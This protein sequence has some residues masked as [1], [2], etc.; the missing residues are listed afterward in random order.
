M[1]EKK[2]GLCILPSSMATLSHRLARECYSLRCMEMWKMILLLTWGLAEGA[3]LWFTLHE[4][5]DKDRDARIKPHIATCWRWGQFQP[6]SMVLDS[7]ETFQRCT[8]C[9]RYVCAEDKKST[10]I[11]VCQ[12][13]GSFLEVPWIWYSSHMLPIEKCTFFTSVVMCHF[14][15]ALPTQKH[16]FN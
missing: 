2:E 1:H 16:H 8:T 11:K 4:G 3:G 13:L 12:I 10:R 14:T 9:H 15:C 7:T 5:W 6:N